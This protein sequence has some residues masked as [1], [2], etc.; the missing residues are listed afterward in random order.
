MVRT[1]NTSSTDTSTSLDT[2]TVYAQQ[3]NRQTF[4]E[5]RHS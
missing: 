5:K 3:R 1:I 2:L 4:I